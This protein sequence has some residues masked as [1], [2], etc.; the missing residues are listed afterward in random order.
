MYP[1]LFGGCTRV[2][3]DIDLSPPLVPAF[4][5]RSSVAPIGHYP[6]V[7][8]GGALVWA[9][10][11]LVALN[12]SG[13]VRWRLPGDFAQ[14]HHLCGDDLIVV[15]GEPFNATNR[16]EGPKEW[17]RI[18]VETG[19][20]T[21]SFPGEGYLHALVP[22]VGVC[23]RTDALGEAVASSLSAVRISGTGAEPL[24]RSTVSGS[25]DDLYSQHV[26]VSDGRIF[27]GL[28]PN[29][30]ALD[31]DTGRELWRAP[32]GDLGGAL[33]RDAFPMNSRGVCVVAT[34][35]WTAAFDEKTGRRLWSTPVWG[36]RVV[37]GDS[38][39]VNQWSHLY[40]FDL[41]DGG[42]KLKYDL[43]PEMEK[44]SKRRFD[45]IS[46]DIAASETHI[47]A[48]DPHGTLWAL[49]RET[50][51]PEWHQ[52]PKGTTGYSGGVPAISGGRLYV[53]SFSLD[54]RFPPSLYCYAQA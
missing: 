48:G 3:V 51:R 32:V 12:E 33:S 44:R 39:Y 18:R 31:L 8:A 43:A 37:Y 24:W 34:K 26:A 49:N 10:K 29:I 1:D 16:G 17:Q 20:L 52:K 19:G 54:A 50:G 11:E 28:P 22:D 2:Q 9:T 7:A 27:V 40:A 25:W 45:R 14:G 23:G 15:R 21:S 53:P 4:Q 35:D 41:F 5:W 46:T 13:A 42:L 6:L 36:A 30:V 38:V 47:W